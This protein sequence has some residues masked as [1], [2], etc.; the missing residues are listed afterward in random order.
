[1]VVA[2]VA[3]LGR[4]ARDGSSGRSESEGSFLGAGFRIRTSQGQNSYC[5]L[6]EQW[7]GK[8]RVGLTA[9]GAAFLSQHSNTSGRT[10]GR[11]AGVT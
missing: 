1:M 11:L 6:W 10:R 8:R 2:M 7:E 4:R 3:V 5:C 9:S